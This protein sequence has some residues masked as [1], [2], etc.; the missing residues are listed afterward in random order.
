MWK[1]IRKKFKDARQPDSRGLK[2][3]HEGNHATKTLTKFDN[4]T[5]ETRSRL[6]SVP[7]GIRISQMDVPT[8]SSHTRG[9]LR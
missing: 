3:D 8:S 2:Q 9:N 5:F 1:V 7:L 6:V 4:R